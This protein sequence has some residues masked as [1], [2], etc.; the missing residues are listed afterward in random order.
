MPCI[1]FCTAIVS[2]ASSM[3]KEYTINNPLGVQRNY[4]TTVLSIKFCRLSF[5]RVWLH[6]G[7]RSSGVLFT[8][9]VFTTICAYVKRSY[10]DI[11]LNTVPG[12]IP[13]PRIALRT[14]ENRRCRFS[15]TCLI[16]SRATGTRCSIDVLRDEVVAR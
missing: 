8:D 15:K 5:L 2:E 3:W 7:I 12:H 1:P 6:F 11:N 14:H 13:N 10:S 9:G 4:A 16:C